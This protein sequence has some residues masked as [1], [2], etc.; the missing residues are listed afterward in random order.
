[1]AKRTNPNGNDPDAYFI[2]L[3]N[4]VKTTANAAGVA[5]A[6]KWTSEAMLQIIPL[7]E[8][9]RDIEIQKDIRP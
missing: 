3:Q 9:A 2:S 5:E 8:T 1:M 4:A 6:A 7:I